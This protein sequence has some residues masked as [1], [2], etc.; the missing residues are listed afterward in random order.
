MKKSGDILR[1][2]PAGE[3]LEAK[4]RRY[5]AY[6]SARQAT[7]K[8]TWR[9]ALGLVEMSVHLGDREARSRGV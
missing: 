8:L 4:S 7:R 5:A 1:L 6:Y 3:E 9:K 2:Q